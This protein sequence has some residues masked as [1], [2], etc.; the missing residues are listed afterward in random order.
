M[1]VAA[2]VRSLRVVGAPV[3]PV[4]YLLVD[5]KVLWGAQCS[6]GPFFVLLAL[7]LVIGSARA[8]PAR[9]ALR[10]LRVLC[11]VGRAASKVAWVL[12][13]LACL[14][15]SRIVEA[16]MHVTSGAGAFPLRLR[17]GQV[18]GML[19]E[20]GARQVKH[21]R[22]G[23]LLF[24]GVGWYWAPRRSYRTPYRSITAAPPTF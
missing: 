15:V 5:V 22:G 6:R 24:L 3:L 13:F 1:D 17:K 23:A 18:Q 16:A 4:P 14:S 10:A 19:R 11:L 21:Q 12:A 20:L 9:W 2:V 7:R 8:V